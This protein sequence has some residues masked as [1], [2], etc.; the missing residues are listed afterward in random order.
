MDC[1]SGTNTKILELIGGHHKTNGPGDTN[2]FMAE[3]PPA[4]LYVDEQAN[5]S[6]H[7]FFTSCLAHMAYIIV[8]ADE[9]AIIDPL[10]ELD[11]YIA[12]LRNKGLKLK[13]IFETH[14]HADFVSGH[15]DLSQKTGAH[16]VF[17][18]TAQGDC[19]ILVAKDLEKF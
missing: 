14:F 7:Q 8:S 11:P 5:F 4:A 13:Y 16:I 10:R 15:F 12:F 9:A 3:M 1:N 2:I 17:G 18:P 19:D 6:V